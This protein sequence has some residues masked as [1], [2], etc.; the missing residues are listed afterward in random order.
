MGLFQAKTQEKREASIIS[1]ATLSYL[2]SQGK[3]KL[4]SITLAVVY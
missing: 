2:K 3:K 1:S 4:K